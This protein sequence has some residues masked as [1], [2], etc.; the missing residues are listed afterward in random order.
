M[1]NTGDIQ[2]TLK[3]G[4]D[5]VL[6]LTPID[7]STGKLDS[8]NVIKARM[9]GESIQGS[10]ESLESNELKSGRT[11]SKKKLGNESSEGSLDFEFSPDTFDALLASALRG[12]WATGANSIKTQF[13]DGKY[14]T[15]SK[16]GND[17]DILGDL[18]PG[19]DPNDYDIKKLEVDT[20]SQE[21]DILRKLGGL[22]GEDMWQRYQKMGVN[23]FDIDVSTNSIVTGSFGFMGINSPKRVDDDAIK[24]AYGN[25]SGDVVAGKTGEEF[26]ESLD[27]AESTNTDQFVSTCGNLW[28]NG[29]N[30]THSENISIS[31]NNNL[32][33][34]NA[35]MVKKAIA[36]TANRLDISGNYQSYVVK[37]DSTYEGSEP[38]YN[39]AVDNETVEIMFVLQDK[40][41]DPK[42]MYLFQIRHAAFDAP[43]SNNNGTDT[44]EDSLGYTSFDENPLAIYKISK[45]SA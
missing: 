38:V 43:S 28:I 2:H 30:I 13:V 19:L 16:N 6:Y 5:E 35:I 29:Q 37:G 9:T 40:E 21:F 33:R 34:K 20:Q 18:L 41:T 42:N 39:A 8:A 44:Y 24:T 15:F 14:Q 7:P 27:S 10:V 3:T 22:S 11:P 36:T 45:K 1:A 23:T 25:N 31:L 12:I 4:A 32:E 26:I 17:T